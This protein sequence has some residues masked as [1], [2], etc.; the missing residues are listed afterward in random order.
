MKNK[1]K[2]NLLLIIL[3][4]I[5]LSVFLYSLVNIIKW[6]ID[7]K[8]TNKVIDELKNNYEIIEMPAIN[9]IENTDINE[10]NK[11]ETNKIIKI[12][13]DE[14]KTKNSDTKGWIKVEGT[15]IDY[16]FVQSKDNKYYLTHSF[17]KKYTD[18]GWVFMDYRNNIDELDK[19]TIIYAHA[20]KDRT[21]FGSLKWTLK[22]DWQ[23]NKDNHI[24][25]ITT[26]NEELSFQVFSTYHYKT[27]DYYITTNFNSDSEF[28]K[29]ANTL[30]KRSNHNYNVELNEN[31]YILTLS[32]CY[33]SEEK[34]V[35]H[36]KL[37]KRETR[38]Y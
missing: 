11:E 33:T 38:L 1:N 8:H 27:E 7:N 16:P 21:M 32:S 6:F 28:L 29:F 2:S 3:T 17:D 5:F 22:K 9:N 14:L 25:K 12:N 23:S 19:N 10:E 15:N 31:D 36:A 35:L 26:E 13:F 18:A 30:K 20:R 34:V 37:I 24:I 4:I